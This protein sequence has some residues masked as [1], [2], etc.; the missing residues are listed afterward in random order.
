LNKKQVKV[1]VIILQL[2]LVGALF[3]PAGKISGATGTDDSSLSVFGMID[4]YAGMGF[5]DDARFYM[6][7]ACVFPAAIIFSVLFIKERKNFGAATILSAFYSAASACFFSS[8]KIKM[9][10][11]ATLTKLPYII[12]IVS[13]ISMIFLILGFFYAAPINGNNEDN[14]KNKP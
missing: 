2:F 6:I 13:L 8:S 7:L 3:L 12:I 14:K 5:S 4:R 1:I 11:Y 10:D 9:I